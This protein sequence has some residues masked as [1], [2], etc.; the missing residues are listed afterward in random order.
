MF[1]DIPL[2]TRAQRYFLHDGSA[3]TGQQTRDAVPE[4]VLSWS[5][6]WPLS[7][8]N[9]SPRSPDLIPPFN[10]HLWEFVKG[11]VY[12]CDV[13]TR[14]DLILRTI[15]EATRINDRD[16]LR[17]FTRSVVKQAKIC[18]EAEIGHYEHSLQQ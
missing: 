12:E 13:D 14:E 18:T 16:S 8:Q 4:S 1:E 17:R 7:P 11:L 3:T 10:F 15:D 5:L 2:T 6:D 9:W